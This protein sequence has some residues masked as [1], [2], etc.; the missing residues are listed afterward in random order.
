MIS[1]ETSKNHILVQNVVSVETQSGKS[2]CPTK[3]NLN[4]DQIGRI[5]MP[6]FPTSIDPDW[7]LFWKILHTW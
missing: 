5:M 6:K 2:S 1:N 3:I 7:C 4:L